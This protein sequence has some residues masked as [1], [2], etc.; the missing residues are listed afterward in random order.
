M[1]IFKR[2]LD[3]EIFLILL[4]KALERYGG[5]LHAYCLMTNHYHM[6]METEQQEIWKIMKMISH[7]YAMYFNSV[8]GYKGHLFEG[9]YKACIV[10][11][12]AYFLQTSRYIHLNPVKAGIVKYPEDYKWSSYCTMIGITD[13]KLTEI[14]KTLSYFKPPC[15][16]RY[17]EFLEDIGHKYVMNE[18]NIRKEMGENE[19][20]LPW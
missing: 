4:K 5:R 11:D 12:D 9:R 13:D 3:Y 1:E 8:N 17:R 2:S 15:T 18:E 20:W 19:I 6:L 7:Q 16:S 10:Q 14:N